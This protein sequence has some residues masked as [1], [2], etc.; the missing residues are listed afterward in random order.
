MG[1]EGNDTAASLLFI[2]DD[3]NTEAFWKEPD[4]VL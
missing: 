4:E 2:R 3:K 1:S